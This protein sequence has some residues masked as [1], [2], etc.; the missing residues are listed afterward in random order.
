M[1]TLERLTAADLRAVISGFA[2]ALAAHREPINRLNVY[3][4]PDGDTGTN[5]ALTLESVVDRARRRRRRPGRDLQGHRPRLAHGRP[6]QLRRDPLARSCG[7]CPTVVR[8]GRRRSTAPRWP[9]RSTPAVR[10]PPTARSCARS[11]ARS[12]PSC[13]RRPRR[14]RPRP[15]AAPTLVGVLEA[16]PDAGAATRWP[17][18]PELLPVLAEAGVVDAGGTGFLLL[19]DVAPP[20]GRRAAGA[21]AR[22]VEVAGAS[23][24][25]IGPMAAHGDG[26]HGEAASPTCATR[27][28]TSSRPP[29]ETI[30]GFKDVWAGIGDSIVVVGGD[31][32][33]NC[34]IHTDDI[35][36][37]IEAAHRR[38]PAPPHPGHRPARAGRGGALGPRGRADAGRAVDR[39]RARSPPRSWP[40]PT[41]DGIRRIFHSLGVQGIVTGGQTMNPST[42]Q[43]LEAVEAAPAD[44]GRDPAQQQEHH[45]GRRA[46]RRP[47][48]QDGARRAHPGRGRGLRLAA[49]LRPRGRRPTTTPRRW[50]RPPRRRRR[51]R[52]HPG[53]ARLH[54]ATSGPI[55]RA[56]T[57]AS[58]ATASGPSAT[59]SAGA[60]T[61]LLDRAGRPTS[62]RSSPSSRARAP[63]PADHPPHHGVAATT[64]APGVERRGP[65]RRPAALPVP[66]RHRVAA[67]PSTAG[68]T[69]AITS[70]SSPQLPGHRA[71]GRRRAARPR[72]ARPSS[73]SR[74]CST[75]SPTTR[76]ATSTAPTQ[77]PHRRP[78]RGARRRLVLVTVERVDRRGAPATG[79]VAGRRSTSPT[80][81]GHLQV[82]F[83]NQPWRERQLQAGHRGRPVRQAR[84]VPGP[85]ADDQPGRRPRRRPHR[86][87]RAGLP[88]VGEGRRD[89]RWDIGRVDGRGA[90][91]GRRSFADPVPDERAATASTS[92]TGRRPSTTSTRPSRWRDGGGGPPPPGVRRAAAGAAGAGAAQ[93]GARAR[94]P[95]ASRHDV[96]AA[97][98]ASSA[99]STSGCPFPL[100]GAQRR[101]IAEIDADLAGPPPDAPAAA[102]RRRRRQD[103]RGRGGAARRGAGRPPG[104]AHGADRGAGRAAHL[105]HP[106]PARRRRRCPTTARQPVRRRRRRCGSS[107]SPTARRR[108]SAAASWPAWPTATVDLVIG[109]HALIQEG[110]EFRSLGVVVIDEQHRF[111]VEQRAALRDKGAGERRARRAGHDRHADPAHRGH[112][113]LRRPRR[114]GARRA[115]AGAHPDRHHVGARARATTRP[116]C[117]RRCATEV[118][119]G[120]QA[121][122]VCPLIEE[123]EKLEVR[124]A[125]ETFE[126]LARG[127][128]AGPAARAAARP[129]RGRPR[130][131][132]AMDAVPRAATLDVLVATTVI[133]VGVDVPNATVMVILDADRFGIAQLHQ[134]RG[135]VGPGRGA[136]VRAAWSAQA[137]DPRRRGP[138]R[139]AGA[140]H[141]RLRA[142]RGRPRPA[143]RGHD[144]GRAPEGPQRPQAGVAA[145]RPRVGRAGPGGG[146]RARRRRPRPRPPPR[147]WPARSTSSSTRTR[148]TSCSRA[149]GGS[150]FYAEVVALATTSA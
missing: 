1:P 26:G 95:R 104:R 115:A 50:P 145:P 136:V 38:R 124:S 116:R 98:L 10:R 76:G 30:P 86:A 135:R 137:D 2:D 44:A 97:R 65:P 47:D 56:T 90:A 101:V 7:A 110:V 130:R 123:R 20:R 17:R 59:T 57:S 63:A 88:A 99:G 148:P 107:C 79:A 150:H 114:V 4:V 128:A 3:P 141:R 117:G 53:R 140:H 72:R 9:A 34:H 58:P 83:F 24:E 89:R 68:P 15:T 93:A 64:T 111:G 45:P 73:G 46:G 139:G 106:G 80:A 103:R 28:C 14:P 8:G 78:R 100:T 35:G 40:W 61:A 129:G 37:A 33:W 102:G 16:G 49:R 36:A 143:G 32:L 82:T 43:L 66:L 96:G 118:A 81:S 19:L 132:P 22:R 138:A 121:Y 5:M 84:G 25:L 67:P 21:R 142:G 55:P 18:T 119:A 122:V 112:D 48:R 74:R 31:G 87:H 75:C 11:R 13:G 146:V 70:P 12:S 60:A 126:R 108:P 149:E 29:D 69:V 23:A 131:R 41:G 125:E 105:G 39:P 52:G 85:A 133:E 91:P 134:L 71:E 92:S 113:R 54:H 62:T 51:R 147:Y 120:R 27:S 42:A 109:T 127:R 144:H 94:R 77:A 6:G